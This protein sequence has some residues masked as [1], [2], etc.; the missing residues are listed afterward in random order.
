MILTKKQNKKLKFDMTQTFPNGWRWT[1]DDDCN[2]VIRSPQNDIDLSIN[3]GEGTNEVSLYVCT[4]EEVSLG[5]VPIEV[6]QALL[7]SVTD[8]CA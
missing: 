1:Q 7:K 8:A 4:T 6:L 5:L 3:V 2:A